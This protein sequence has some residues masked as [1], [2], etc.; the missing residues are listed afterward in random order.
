MGD[1]VEF[2]PK[3]IAVSQHQMLFEII[4]AML[5]QFKADPPETDYQRG[6]EGC[7]QVLMDDYIKRGVK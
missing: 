5:D 1:V 2:R 3:V 4:P 7:L 6:F